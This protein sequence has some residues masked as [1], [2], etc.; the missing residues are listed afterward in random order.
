MTKAYESFIKAHSSN[1]ADKINGMYLVN[2][3]EMTAPELLATEEMLINEAMKFDSAAIL[4]LGEIKTK[5]AEATL[6]SLLAKVD[7]P[8][9]LHLSITESLWNVSQDMSLQRTILE[10]FTEENDFLRRRAALL[11]K[12]TKPSPVTHEAFIKML[13]NETNYVNRTIAA[14]GLLIHY[15]LM[16]SSRDNSGFDYYSYLIN[17]LC[18]SNDDQSLDASIIE[19]EKESAKIKSSV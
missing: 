7:A 13:K 4:G 14:E 8:S 16:K 19:V 18:E 9:D 10:D 5:K 1:G 11:L 15:G 2:Y 6:R 3:T 12:N 17:Q